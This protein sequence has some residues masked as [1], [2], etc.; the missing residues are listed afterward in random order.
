MLLPESLGSLK[1][2]QYLNAMSNRLIALPYGIGG[3]T[4]LVRCAWGLLW[5]CLPACT[6]SH[7]T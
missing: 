4:S 6:L 3:C 7:N 1:R 2:L 5:W